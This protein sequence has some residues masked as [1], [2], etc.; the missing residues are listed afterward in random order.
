MVQLQLLEPIWLPMKLPPTTKWV[1]YFYFNFYHL[2]CLLI[3]F[4]EQLEQH[5][6][7]VVAD[8]VARPILRPS[9][10]DNRTV[11]TCN[12]DSNAA[13]RICFDCKVTTVCSPCGHSACNLCLQQ[14]IQA[15]EEQSPTVC[16]LCRTP[17]TRFIIFFI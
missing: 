10:P 6:P 13:C 11:E 14:C 2:A 15:T 1:F 8:A 5:L 17:V 7:A 16:P 12:P 9:L 4:Y 3:F